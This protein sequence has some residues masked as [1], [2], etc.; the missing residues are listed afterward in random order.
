MAIELIGQEQEFKWAGIPFEKRYSQ[1]ASAPAG[2]LKRM[3]EVDP[4]LDLKFYMPHERWHVVRYPHGRGGEF[5]RVWE[6]EDDPERGLRKD[7]GEWIIGALIAGDTRRESIEERI[8]EVDENNKKIED[9]AEKEI[10]LQAKDTAKDL[11]KCI[12]NWHDYGPESETHLN[13]QVGA[14]L[15]KEVE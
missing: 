2:L 1:S 10:E 8:R 7:L 4:L 3:Q 6:C 11:C 12:S 5:V 15:K 13:Y 9:A 14:D